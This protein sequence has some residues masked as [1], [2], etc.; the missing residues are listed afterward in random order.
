LHAALR[1][2]APVTASRLYALPDVASIAAPDTASDDRADL[3]AA[4]AR[5]G[6]VTRHRR[7]QVGRSA[8]WS[9]YLLQWEGRTFLVGKGPK[10]QR[11]RLRLGRG[12][13]GT[14]AT[15]VQTD[16]KNGAYAVD[17][18]RLSKRQVSL[19]RHQLETDGK[20][21]S[22]NVEPV[23]RAARAPRESA[24][25]SSSLMP[26][27]AAALVVLALLAAVAFTRRETVFGRIRRP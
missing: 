22:V 21:S 13:G 7:V 16:P 24:R 10:A 3:L 8:A 11:A 5:A 27:L 2:T 15:K 26:L 4:V 17:L 23:R 14:V 19:L 12:I 18:G 20:R 1:I 9:G 6:L 25:R